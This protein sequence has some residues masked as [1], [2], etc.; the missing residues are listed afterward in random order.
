MPDKNTPSQPHMKLLYDLYGS[1]GR[2]G[3]KTLSALNAEVA[4][5]QRKLKGHNNDWRPD[6]VVLCAQ[7][8]LCSAW[9]FVNQERS[10]LDVA[11]YW[12]SLGS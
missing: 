1:S 4:Q 2:T 3:C 12:A 8:A 7:S 10:G 6:V 5:Y 11:V 9:D